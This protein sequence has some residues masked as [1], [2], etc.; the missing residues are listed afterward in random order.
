MIK[1]IGIEKSFGAQHV[2]KGVDINL[3]PGEITA[4]LGP[5]GTGKSV[6]LKILTG[7]IEADKG[8]VWVGDQCLGDAKNADE[9]RSICSKM[10]V[11]FQT[12]ALFDSLSLFDN[13]AFPLRYRGRL[14]GDELGEEEIL[15]RSFDML[16]S[17][18]LL[19]KEN[20]LPGEVSI[21][22]RKRAGIA[23]ALVTKPEVILFDEPNTALDPEMG[24]EIYELIKETHAK[25]NFTGIVV[26]HEIPEV[27][28]VCDQVVMLYD[29]VVQIDTSVEEFVDCSIPVVKQFVNGEIEGPIQL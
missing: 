24:Q 29:G 26:S 7:L 2:L 25:W 28:Q 27:F 10:G 11:L 17:V 15:S 16:E 18:G 14:Y 1:A 3:E 20:A 8:E 5:S 19:G 4:I 23:R 21:G 12:A 9:R 6:F 13:I 22:M